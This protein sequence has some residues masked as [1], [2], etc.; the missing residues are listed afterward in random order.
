MQASVGH[1][2]GPTLH[3]LGVIFS[4]ARHTIALQGSMR[5]IRLVDGAQTTVPGHYV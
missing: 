3:G 5:S 2:Q 1:T 4:T